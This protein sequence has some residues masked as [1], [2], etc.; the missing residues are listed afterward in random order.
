MKYVPHR[1]QER[2]TRFVIDTPKCA[3]FLDMGLGKSVIALTA[4]QQL[5]EDYL[6]VEKV[7]VIAP[8]SVARNTWTTEPAKWD[9]LKGLRVSLV[10]GSVR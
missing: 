10:A 4:I 9:H 8:K 6:E 1:Y 5:I 3:L 2:A 7:L